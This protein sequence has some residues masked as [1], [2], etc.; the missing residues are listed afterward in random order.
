MLNIHNSNKSEP[1]LNEEDDL[2]IKSKN[3][4]RRSSI[5]SISSSTFKVLP[6]ITCEQTSKDE[7]KNDESGEI[8]ENED[9]DSQANAALDETDGTALDLS[10]LVKELDN[11]N[12]KPQEKN[13]SNNLPDDLPATEE[14]DIIVQNNL[15]QR[16]KTNKMESRQNRYH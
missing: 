9:D 12:E 14:I 8:K 2:Q 6:P 7:S 13:S 5:S 3:G 11:G 10:T 4:S 16:S 15:K 1:V